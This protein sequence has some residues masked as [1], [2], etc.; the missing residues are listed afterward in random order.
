MHSRFTISRDDR[1]LF[2]VISYDEEDI[3]V[4]RQ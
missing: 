4:G 1:S 3:W 2:F